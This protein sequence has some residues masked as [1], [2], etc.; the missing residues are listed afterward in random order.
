MRDEVALEI[1]K[2]SFS[3][4]FGPQSDILQNSTL[5]TYSSKICAIFGP[6][7]FGETTLIKLI[8]S[9]P[10]ISGKSF[11]LSARDADDLSV[12]FLENL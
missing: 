10:P 12:G 6:C 8:I 11:K 3:D 2:V 1:E 4:G 7:R 5:K 9:L